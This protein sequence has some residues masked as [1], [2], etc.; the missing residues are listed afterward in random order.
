MSNLAVLFI[1]GKSR[2]E[3]VGKRNGPERLGEPPGARVNCIDTSAGNLRGL[4]D[5]R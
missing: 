3:I 5:A 2:S 1:L 4:H